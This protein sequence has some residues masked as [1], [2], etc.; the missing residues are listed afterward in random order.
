[1]NTK[2]LL[3][4]SL[5]CGLISIVLVNTPFV[6]L[7]N[8]LVCAGF[9]IGPIASVWLYRRLGG[10]LMFSQALLVSLLA[11]AWHW[12]FGVLLSPLGLTG[13]GGLLNSVQSFMPAQDLSDLESSLTGIGGMLFYLV[14]LG[15]DLAFG[16]IG[17]L[18]GGTFLGLRRATVQ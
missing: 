8:L 15:I 12:L 10:S 16:F 1:M 13:A 14:A 17:G 5:A 11:G 9:W 2:N 6:N 7:I 3:V 18:I 4:A